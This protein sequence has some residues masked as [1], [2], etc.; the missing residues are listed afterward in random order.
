M[1]DQEERKSDLKV[2]GVANAKDF[3]IL[4]ELSTP[5]LTIRSRRTMRILLRSLFG[6]TA[7]LI[8]GLTIQATIRAQGRIVIKDRFASI[9][10]VKHHYLVAG[11]GEP[12]IMNLTL[13]RRFKRRTV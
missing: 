13:Q 2:G 8:P 4:R 9:N 11:K 7:I 10:G 5:L 6:L 3:P 1:K 12:V